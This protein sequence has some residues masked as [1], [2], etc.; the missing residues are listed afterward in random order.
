MKQ[1]GM[2]NERDGNEARIIWEVNLVGGGRV[3]SAR[4]DK[5]EKSP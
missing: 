2:R 3:F 1:L 5:S 4:V